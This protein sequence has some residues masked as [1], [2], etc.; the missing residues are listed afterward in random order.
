MVRDSINV[1]E[2]LSFSK[3]LGD[4]QIMAKLSKVNQHLK[5]VATAHV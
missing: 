3:V 1:S 5:Q 4:E 2:R